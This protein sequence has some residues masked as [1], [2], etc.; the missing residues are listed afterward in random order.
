M[1]SRRLQHTAFFTVNLTMTLKSGAAFSGLLS[2]G[3]FAVCSV[4]GSR[5]YNQQ[6]PPCA[7][8]QSDIED[9]PQSDAGHTAANRSNECL[10]GNVT[11]THLR[12]LIPVE[13]DIG[14]GYMRVRG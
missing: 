10:E 1:R 6:S 11:S 9:L 8:M 4:G 3:E 5:V 7:H 2:Y 14:K 12:R 13:I